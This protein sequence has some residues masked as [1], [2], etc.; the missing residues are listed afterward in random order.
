MKRDPLLASHWP[1]SRVR[2]CL[3]RKDKAALVQF[4]K[5]R[6]EERFFE[7]LRHL[8]TAP[9]NIQGYGF[10]M[11]AL[12]ALL[13]ET[14]QSYRDGL[15][16]TFPPGLNRLRNMPRV[17][18]PYRIPSNLRI[19]GKQAFQRFFRA[20]TRYFS[21]LSGGRFYKNIRN[22]LLHQGQ[23]K[24]GWTLSK[25]GPSVWDA[26]AKV[27]FRD[28]FAEQLEGA[29]GDYLEELQKRGWNHRQWTN[30]ARKIWWLIHL[31]L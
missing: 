18:S 3:R 12:C 13:V 6:H 28:N 25:R 14:I 7:P 20:Q 23:T 8:K 2:Q 19:N 29:F 17:P 4:L 11:M 24:A 5:E 27:I 16:T 10:A 15:P 9:G 30:A 1:A 21:G 26:K 22:G 31:S